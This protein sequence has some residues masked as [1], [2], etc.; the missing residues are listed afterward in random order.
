VDL[1]HVRLCRAASL[2]DC[3]LAGMLYVLLCFTGCFPCCCT[4]VQVK[5]AMAQTNPEMHAIERTKVE[6]GL[7]NK[8]LSRLSD[9]LRFN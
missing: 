8:R 1:P 2:I 4:A 3:G 6:C 7:A 9:V 5:H